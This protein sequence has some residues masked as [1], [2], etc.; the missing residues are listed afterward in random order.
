MFYFDFHIVND[1]VNLQFAISNQANSKYKEFFLQYFSLKYRVMIA[2][3]CPR[4][5]LFLWPSHECR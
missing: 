2:V 3:L 5:S 4:R 1:E